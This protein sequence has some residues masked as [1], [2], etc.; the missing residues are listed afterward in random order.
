MAPHKHRGMKKGA[1]SGAE[2]QNVRIQVTHNPANP[3]AV[4][5]RGN[6]TAE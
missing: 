6:W 1:V 4:V 5:A 2:G 3:K